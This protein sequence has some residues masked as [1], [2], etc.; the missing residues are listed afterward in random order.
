MPAAHGPF[1][2][3]GAGR[4]GCGAPYAADRAEGYGNVGSRLGVHYAHQA[5]TE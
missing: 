5:F 3:L 4:R 1:G 2:G